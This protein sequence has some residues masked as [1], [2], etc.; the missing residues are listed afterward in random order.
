MRLVDTHRN[1]PFLADGSKRELLVRFWYPAPAGRP[2]E[3]APYT[4]P[5]VWADLSRLVGISLPEVMTN[6]CLDAPISGRAHPVVVFSHGY[7]GLFTDATFLLEDLA[8]RGFVVASVAHT[9]ESTAVEFPGGRLVKSVLG[10]YLAPESLRLDSQAVSSAYSTRLED[11]RFV[12]DELWRLKA[13]RG[14]PLEGKLDVSHMAV[15][16]YSLEGDVAIASA[17]REA[18]FRA[19]VALEPIPLG[20]PSPEVSKPVLIL[21]A[22][23]EQWSNEECRQWSN[24]RGLRLAI[25]LAGGDHS[26]PSDAVWLSKFVPELPVQVGDMGPEK[27]VAAIRGYVAAFLNLNL[28]GQPQAFLSD[29][30]SLSYPDAVVTTQE[31][32]PCADNGAIAEGGIQ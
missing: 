22:G 19:A 6:S 24:L 17:A 30:S 7:T 32:S 31:Q 29:G 14:S 5:E 23:R 18:R 9:Y 11:L 4:S 1:N 20:N 27:T 28:L 10:S 21:T 8:S 25:D 2:C 13:S 12:L 3:P 16:G 26:T 15:V